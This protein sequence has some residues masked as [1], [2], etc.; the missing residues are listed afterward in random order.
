MDSPHTLYRLYDI[1]GR[2]LY[3][4]ITSDWD[5]RRSQHAADK[6]WWPRVSQIAL[7]ELPSRAH[8][9]NAERIAIRTE[10]PAY[11][12]VGAGG[13][14]G[15]IVDRSPKITWYCDTCGEVIERGKGGA[16]APGKYG[17]YVNWSVTHW[18]YA[19]RTATR[20]Q[21]RHRWM[22][23]ADIATV[24]R[25]LFATWLAIDLGLANQSNWTSLISRAQAYADYHQRTT[26]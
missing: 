1:A 8:A 21:Y 23:V 9:L 15:S 10:H 13:R 16:Y 11:N 19:C 22:D 20:D 25:F 14:P 26:P 3:V 17:D 12:Q 5:R 4:G 2:L 24:D 18:R 6:A 7:A